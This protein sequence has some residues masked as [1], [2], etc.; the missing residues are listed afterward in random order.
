MGNLFENINDKTTQQFL[1]ILMNKSVQKR[2][3]AVTC[4]HNLYLKSI[5][6]HIH[7]KPQVLCSLV[8]L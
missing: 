1:Y 7:Y 5:C 8:S 2:P 6:T 4:N 3:K